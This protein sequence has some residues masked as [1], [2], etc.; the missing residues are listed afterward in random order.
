M[1]YKYF[2]I[3]KKCELRRIHGINEKI[4]TKQ[5]PVFVLVEGNHCYGNQA[6]YAAQDLKKAYPKCRIIYGASNM[7]YKYQDVVKD[8]EVC[9]YGNLT[10]CCKELSDKECEKLGIQY[11]KELLFPWENVDEEWEIVELKQ[12]Q[13]NNVEQIRQ[14]AALIVE[15]N[16]N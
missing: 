14:Q 5:D 15:Y 6:K 10:N 2:F 3:D 4:I 13:Y 1:Q 16:L 12:H 11:K 9:F 7:D 8:A